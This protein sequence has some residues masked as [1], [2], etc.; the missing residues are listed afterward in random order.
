MYIIFTG[1]PGPQPHNEQHRVVSQ[2]QRLEA[3][4]TSAKGQRISQVILHVGAGV[5]WRRRPEGELFMC[6]PPAALSF[7]LTATSERPA[8]Q[9][10]LPHSKHLLCFRLPSFLEVAACSPTSSFLSCRS[11]FTYHLLGTTSHSIKSPVLLV[12]RAPTGHFSAY[13]RFIYFSLV[14]ACP[15]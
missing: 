4:L 3:R 14:P 15:L 8:Y 1:W 10:S 9:L 5:P 11:Q 13:A 12:S 6:H 7:P 2:T